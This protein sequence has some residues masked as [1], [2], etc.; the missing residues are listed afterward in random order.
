MVA[1][2]IVLPKIGW[3]FWLS[4]NVA[5]LVVMWV[6]YGLVTFDSDPHTPVSAR[7]SIPVP[8]LKFHPVSGEQRSCS[9]WLSKSGLISVSVSRY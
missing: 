4:S 3:A 1:P 5:N 9:G 8:S 7:L 2:L 6:R